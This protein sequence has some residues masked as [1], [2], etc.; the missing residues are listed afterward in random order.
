MIT[1]MISIMK[2]VSAISEMITIMISIRIVMM[3]SAISEM[4]SFGRLVIPGGP[5]EP[6]QHLYLLFTHHPHHLRSNTGRWKY[7]WETV[8]HEKTKRSN[9]WPKLHLVR[10]QKKLCF[11]SCW[12]KAD[13]PSRSPYCS[14]FRLNLKKLHFFWHLVVLFSAYIRE[15]VKKIKGPFFV[16]F[17]YE[18]ILGQYFMLCWMP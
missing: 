1:I 10:R 2:M 4:I 18:E 7:F 16:I 3:I 5:R 6:T 14:A 12:C 17:Y 15:G 8:G 11:G 9:F 13:C